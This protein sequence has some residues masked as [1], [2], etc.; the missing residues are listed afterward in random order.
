LSIDKTTV[1]SPTVVAFEIRPHPPVLGVFQF[2]SSCGRIFLHSTP[3]QQQFPSIRPSCGTDW[4]SACFAD[5]SVVFSVG[6]S[7]CTVHD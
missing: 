4:E 6:E 7:C 2:D 3:D 5:E 1:Q